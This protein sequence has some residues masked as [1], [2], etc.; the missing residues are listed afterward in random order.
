VG[1][2]VRGRAF[3]CGHYIP[4]QA[5]GELLAEVVPFFLGGHGK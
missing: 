5:P 3:D 2:D 4:E 1:K